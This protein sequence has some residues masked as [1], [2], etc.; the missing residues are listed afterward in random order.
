MLLSGEGSRASNRSATR[1]QMHMRLHDPEEI[2]RRVFRAAARMAAVPVIGER[3][4]SV[5]LL[6]PCSGLLWLEVGG[7]TCDYCTCSM[8]CDAMFGGGAGGVENM[9]MRRGKSFKR[10]EMR[11]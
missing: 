5:P 7:A 4:T 3:H 1:V 6:L 9:V 10:I 11:I 2:L 8:A